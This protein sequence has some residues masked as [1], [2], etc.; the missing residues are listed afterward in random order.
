[1]IDRMYQDGINMNVQ[2]LECCVLLG[3]ALFVKTLYFSR[4]VTRYSFSK[5]DDRTPPK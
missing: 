2:G 1:M 4:K 3:L 5:Y